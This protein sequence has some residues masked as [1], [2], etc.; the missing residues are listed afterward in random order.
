MVSVRPREV[1]VSVRSLCYRYPGA[2]ED[3]LR[4]PSLDISGAGLIALTGP[5]G[6]GKTTLVE[7]LAGT[8]R[9]EYQG[10]LSVLGK[11]WRE[12]VRDADRQRQMRRIG[13]I[14]QDFGLLSSWTPREA[15]EQDLSDAGVPKSEHAGRISR[16]LEQVGLSEFA[17]RRISGLSG[18]QRQRVSIARVL[19][20]DVDLVIA[21][22]PTAN[23]DPDRVGEI[24]GLLRK[25]AEGA[26]VIVVTHDPAVAESCDRT[27]VLQSASAGSRN[28]QAIKQPNDRRGRRLA[29]WVAVAC[30]ICIAGVLGA[31]WLWPGGE[32]KQGTSTAHTMVSGSPSPS[33]T[34]APLDVESV[35][36]VTPVQGKKLAVGETVRISVKVLPAAS[37]RSVQILVNGNVTG[38]RLMHP[39]FQVLWKPTAE[40]NYSIVAL[41]V[42]R[43]GSST[44]SDP[45]AIIATAP[46]PSPVTAPPTGAPTTSSATEWGAFLYA[47]ENWGP[48]QAKADRVR[49]MGFPAAVLNTIDYDNLGKP[50][51]AV[52]V[53]C[54]GPYSTQQ[55]AQAA[56]VS[57]AQ[58]GITGAY[59]KEIF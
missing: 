8:V 39:P 15:V 58:H 47:S 33:S 54:A 51:Q 18:G 59:A 37:A 53:V 17:D 30:A 14:P 57:L 20:R 29:L 56:T 7:L 21:D 42:S 50:G 44:K 12:L 40:A 31:V 4:I 34:K 32:A 9:E 13:L 2:E 23:L 38:P 16:S 22:E 19:A 52:W 28:S 41:A 45:V 48:A 49:A 35:G 5:S 6:S 46:T 43:S 26:P 55:E 25:L 24:V 1:L 3:V 27:I 10:S 36:V 11:E